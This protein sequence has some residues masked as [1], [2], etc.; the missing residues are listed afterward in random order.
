MKT[1]NGGRMTGGEL[2]VAMTGSLSGEGAVRLPHLLRTTLNEVIAEMEMRPG[3]IAA[4]TD[5]PVGLSLLDL[6]MSRGGLME[7]GGQCFAGLLPQRLL[8]EAA[9]VTA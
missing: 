7:L 9:G 5:R 1:D 3:R 4:A 2:T 6:L 8:D